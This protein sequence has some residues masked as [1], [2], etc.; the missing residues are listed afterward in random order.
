MQKKEAKSFPLKMP[1]S[2][3][4]G[5]YR[6]WDDSLD[7]FVSANAIHNMQMSNCM[8]TRY[9]S[10]LAIAFRLTA[11]ALLLGQRVERLTER[12]FKRNQS[13]PT[14]NSF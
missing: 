1:R 2:C 9:W 4:S 11:F 5:Q 7:V 6:T 8:R 3:W 14:N 10:I 12:L 13:G